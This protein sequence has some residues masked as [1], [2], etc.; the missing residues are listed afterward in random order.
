MGDFKA[1]HDRLALREGYYAKVSGDAGGET[2]CGITRKNYPGWPGWETIDK[3]KKERG[4]S[5]L[6]HNERLEDLDSEAYAFYLRMYKKY[7]FDKIENASLSELVFDQWVNSGN[8]AVKQFQQCVNTLAEKDG[9][10]AIADD[11]V[12]GPNTAKATNRC[13]AFD[14][15]EE[16]RA[17]REDF[18]KRIAEK[19][20]NK[21][22]LKGWL[23]RLQG[24]RFVESVAS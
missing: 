5:R 4:D 16:F 15:F 19:R 12:F 17:C 11:G 21:K 7:S 14:L 18:Y 10:P 1:I 2:Y 13:D 20:E 22:F 24:I 9:A 6:A 8:R 23:R 3:V